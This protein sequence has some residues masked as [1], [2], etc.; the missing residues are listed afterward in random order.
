[1]VGHAD[2]VAR[3]IALGSAVTSVMALFWS[4]LAWR[5]GG[6]RVKV[7][8]GTAVIIKNW[9]GNPQEGIT[10][11]ARNVGR[12]P[13]Q[14]VRWGITHDR[15]V[16]QLLKRNDDSSEI[17]CVLDAHHERSWFAP[18]VEVRSGYGQDEVVRV[19]G[20]VTLG[21][22]KERKSWRFRALPASLKPYLLAVPDEPR[23]QG[24]VGRYVDRVEHWWRFF[25]VQHRIR[26]RR[27]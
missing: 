7:K 16:T 20:W 3:G 22:G 9:D 19:K 23:R 10:V 11:T 17:P 24:R 12:V 5:L 21:T 18:S 4:M 26:H 14:I 6:S 8:T 15:G 25:R 2:W 1:M 13:A 27:P